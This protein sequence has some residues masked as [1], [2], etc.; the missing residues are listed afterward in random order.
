MKPIDTGED[1]P[2]K[3]QGNEKGQ[4]SQ[5]ELT[6]EQKAGQEIHA[7]FTGKLKPSDIT[8]IPNRL[9]EY[10]EAMGERL[11]IASVP[12]YDNERK[13]FKL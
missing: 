9:Q 6:E 8:P 4:S 3:K 11:V 13:G 2:D 10:K 5:A 7:L 12:K 1:K